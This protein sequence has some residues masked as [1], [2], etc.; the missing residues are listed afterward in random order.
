VAATLLPVL[1]NL[2]ALV[3]A[4]QSL[5][6]LALLLLLLLTA[7]QQPLLMRLQLWQQRRALCL[8]ACGLLHHQ[9]R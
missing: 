7:V 2:V 9:S 5:L 4:E 3:Q 6:L 1:L 8:A